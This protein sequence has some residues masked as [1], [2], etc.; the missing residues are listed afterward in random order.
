MSP[1]RAWS[2]RKRAVSFAVICSAPA[3]VPVSASVPTK[4]TSG[5]GGTSQPAGTGTSQRRPPG[6]DGAAAGA[7][8][9]VGV[10]VGGAS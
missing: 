3:G 9:G 2:S 7:V 10:V 5:S 1:A 6:V 4:T 8:A